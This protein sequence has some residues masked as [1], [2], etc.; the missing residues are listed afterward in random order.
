MKKTWVKIS[1]F[2]L[3]VAL[4]APVAVLAQKEEKV[5][6]KV[7]KGGRQIIVTTKSDNNEK[8]VVEVIG[9]KVTINGKPVEEYG[10]KGEKD[11]NVRVNNLKDL[12]ALTYSRTGKGGTVTYN[13]D[14][15]YN[16]YPS[17]D[18]N[19]AMLG[20]TTG[21]AEGG[22]KINDITKDGG[23]EK[24]GLKEGDIITTIDGKKMEDPDDL[25]ETIRAHKIGDKV[26]ITYLR[27]NKEQKVTAELTKWKGVTGSI[28]GLNLNFDKMATPRAFTM[29][30]TTYGQAFSWS[31]GS[32]KLGIS[33]QDTDDGKGVKVIEVDD[34][35]NAAKAGV[36]EDDVIAEVD[37][38]AVN[39]TDEMVKVIRDSKEKSS[40]LIKLNRAGKTQ[41][42][43]VKMPKKLKTADL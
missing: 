27:D 9:D 25:S 6:E 10:E 30:R 17:M 8:I 2:V 19:R 38:K 5:K 43:E 23:A 3:A 16:V 11:I 31:G 39:S 24:A 40:V 20:V 33:V 34:D 15:F 35:S 1:A 28:N 4:V 42:I 13:G 12:T 32:P 18:S 26:S 22:V 36:K 14:G 29:P 41:S 21:S 7:N 37:G